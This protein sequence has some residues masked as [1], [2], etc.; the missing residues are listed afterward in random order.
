MPFH[1]NVVMVCDFSRSFISIVVLVSWAACGP[2]RAGELGQMQSPFERQP[3]SL[4]GAFSLAEARHG[5][6]GRVHAGQPAAIRVPSVAIPAGSVRA[7][8]AAET[9]SPA[10]R[11]IATPAAKETAASAAKGPAASE[12]AAALPIAERR[13]RLSRPQL[14]GELKSATTPALKSPVQAANPSRPRTAAEPLE[15][16]REALPLLIGEVPSGLHPDSQKP[17]SGAA[18]GV[19]SP[20]VRAPSYR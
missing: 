14:P 15:L 12:P 1:R 6:S 20:Y 4:V 18:V 16:S 19:G 17:M 5:Q 11:E 7:D 3:A 10:A 13:L 8:I 2:L 9:A